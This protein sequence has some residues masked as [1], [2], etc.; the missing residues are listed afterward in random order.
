VSGGVLER[1]GLTYVMHNTE[2]GWKIAVLVTH[3]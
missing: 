1:A 2:Q 3:G